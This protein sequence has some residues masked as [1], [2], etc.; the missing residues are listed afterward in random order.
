M[1]QNAGLY[2][3]V[4]FC[5]RKCGYCDFY[6]VADTRAIPVYLRALEAEMD[7][8][9]GLPWPGMDTVYLGGGTPS[10]LTPRRV[11]RVLDHAVARL[12]V[13][14]DAHVTLEANPG[15]LTRASL[16]AYRAE[17]VRRLNL[18]VQSLDDSTL[19]FLGRVHTARQAR[20]AV[21]HARSA[22][23]DEIGLD[24]IYGIPGRSLADWRR[25][26][27]SALT[28]APEHLSC[29]ILSLPPETPLGRRAASGFLTPVPEDEAARL[30]LF[31]SAF[32][33]AQGYVHY[34]VSNF[35]RGLSHESPHNV[36]YWNRTPYLGLGPS[37]HS[38]LGN[39]RWWNVRSVEGYVERLGQ[40]ESPEEGREELTWD[41]AVTE[42]LFLGLRRKMGLDPTEFARLFGRDFAGLF[43]AL[44]PA[45][46]REGL[47]KEEE[48]GFRPTRRG[49][50]KADGMARRLAG[51]LES[52]T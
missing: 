37:A 48:G 1:S 14:G 15:T 12:P 6:S 36:K 42:W 27:E 40:G 18:G 38:F 51:A 45:L 35:S 44:L 4:P 22:G 25:D 49:L 19:A 50:L 13:A 9:A 5:P 30:F 43:G 46:A 20:L 16:A 31:T 34:E 47:L 41:Q 32:L 11:G 8:A 29:Y 7:R 17:G 28:L 10:L 33:E 24:L 2:I 26:L 39:S 3:H 52:R 21:A 23:F